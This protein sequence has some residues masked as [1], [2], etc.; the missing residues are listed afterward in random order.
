MISYMSLS[1]GL[2]ELMATIVCVS[3]ITTGMGHNLLFW[4]WY[5]CDFCPSEL[6]HWATGQESAPKRRLLDHGLTASWYHCDYLPTGKKTLLMADF[7]IYS[8]DNLCSQA[9]PCCWERKGRLRSAKITSVLTA[10]PP[11][12]QYPKG[13]VC[14]YIGLNCL[15]ESTLLYSCLP[16][17]RIPQAQQGAHKTLGD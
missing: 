1:V 16:F 14:L 6:H 9:G 7:S 8:I 4:H 15:S 10:Y 11:G 17:N 13:Q 5:R 12:E 3:H 2:S